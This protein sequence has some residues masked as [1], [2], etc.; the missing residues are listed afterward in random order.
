MENILYDATRQPSLFP[1]SGYYRGQE[2]HMDGA[3]GKN[4]FTRTL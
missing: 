2:V 4:E 3:I 1:V